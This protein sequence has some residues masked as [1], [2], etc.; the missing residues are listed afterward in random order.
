VRIWGNFL[1]KTYIMIGA[2]PTTLGP[3]YIFRNV[4]YRGR[5]SSQHN[6]NTGAFLKAQSKHMRK[7]FWGGG[8]VYVYHN[9]LL[10]TSPREGTYAGVSG[11]GTD[12]LNYVSRNNIYDN[13]K[14]GMENLGPDSPNDFDYD[15][16]TSMQG[17][18]EQQ[19][20][21][22]QA[23]PRYQSL[24]AFTLVEGSAGH[25]D[26]VVIPNFNDGFVGNAPD[27]GAQELGAAPLRF[28]CSPRW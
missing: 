23:Q 19:R 24:D 5:Y 18:G 22:I 16:Y 1:D 25:D 17:V 11:F 13:T 28:G 14:S 10:R 7:E 15:L 20:H 8:R 21:G 6:F 12:L 3:L 9:T 27:R 26:G 4:C 2:S